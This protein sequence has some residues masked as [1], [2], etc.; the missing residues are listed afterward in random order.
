MSRFF[1]YLMVSGGRILFVIR[2]VYAGFLAEL[3]IPI[4]SF[5][6]GQV[7]RVLCSI[8]MSHLTPLLWIKT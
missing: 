1:A 3:V 6:Q 2:G 7:K 8:E 4:L 5:L